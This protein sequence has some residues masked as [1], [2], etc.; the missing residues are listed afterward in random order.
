[1]AD[2]VT[3][4]RREAV[5]IVRLDRGRRANA[6]SFAIMDALADAARSVAGEP[7]LAAVVL[8]GTA[9]IFSAGMDLR[10]ETFD[11]LGSMSLA[12]KRALAEHGPALARAWAGLEMPTV[13]AVEGACLAGGLALVAMCDF[14]VAGRTAR[15]GAP[16]VQVAHNMGW[17]S[18]P[19]LVRLVG[20]QA[21]RRVLL[22]GEVW[23]AEDARQLGFVDYMA[24]EGHALDEALALAGRI[25]AQPAMATRMVKRQIDA[26]AHGDDW[27][28]SAF[29]KDQQIVAWMS[30]DFARAR[31]KFA[32]K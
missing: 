11:R 7:E 6:M 28:L 29:D 18:V 13:A 22:A 26:A 20:V 15:F 8:T 16:E 32:G 23:T 27:A 30:E 19:R 10:D 1:M 21:T 24:E 25:A 14:R 4:E 31:K 17:H 3:I 2:A 5:A 9:G 12:E